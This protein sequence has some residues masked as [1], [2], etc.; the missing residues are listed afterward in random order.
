MKCPKGQI[1]R[2]GYST[3][4]GKKVKPTCIKDRGL[5]G[6][7]VKLFDLDKDGLSKFG[8]KDVE[9]LT[10][11]QRR[12]AIGKAIRK[13]KPLSVFRRLIALSTLHR[14]IN[15]KLYKIF[16]EDA[17]WIKTRPEYKKNQKG[18]SKS[19]TKTTKSKSKSKTKKKSKSK[20]KRT[21]KSKSK[22]RKR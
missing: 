12:R 17:E 20:A 18:N 7:G 11:L 22:S 19:K 6:K 8:Y 16:R 3:K 2:S 10:Q 4:T 5:P 14:N 9:G 13:L 1:K 21:K 15:T